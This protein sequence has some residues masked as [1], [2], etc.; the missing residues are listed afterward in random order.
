MDVLVRETRSRSGQQ[1][2]GLAAGGKDSKRKRQAAPEE[3]CPYCSHTYTVRD[4]LSS[5]IDEDGERYVV[6]FGLRNWKSVGCH[7][8][9][10]P[11]HLPC[12]RVKALW[13]QSANAQR[14]SIVSRLQGPCWDVEPQ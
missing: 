5:K 10:G 7:A 4:G 8:V 11:L 12:M 14:S 3:G 9:A 13:I 2:S 1:P 6:A